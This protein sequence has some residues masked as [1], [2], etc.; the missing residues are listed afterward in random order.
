MGVADADLALYALFGALV[1]GLI[2]TLL[3]DDVSPRIHLISLIVAIA[4]TV[5]FLSLL[6]HEP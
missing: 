2:T 1:I 3:P 5:L 6:G 4:M